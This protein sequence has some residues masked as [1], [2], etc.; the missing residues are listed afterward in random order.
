MSIGTPID[1]V[2]GGG[3]GV[4][5][6]GETGGNLATDNGRGQ[7]EAVLGG[8]EGTEHDTD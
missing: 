8:V 2:D 5:G 7:A 3:F 1:G 4:T 6:K